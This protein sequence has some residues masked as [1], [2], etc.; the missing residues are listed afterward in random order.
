MTGDHIGRSLRRLEDERFLTGQG[1]YVDDIAVPGQLHGVVLRSPHGHAVIEGIDAAAARVMPGVHGVLTA[2]DLDADGIGTLPCIARVATVAPMVVPP[3]RALARDRVRHVGDP[4]VFVVADTAEQARDAAER[5]DVA[6]RPLP[7]VV[8]AKDA[9]AAQAPLLWDEAPGNLSYRFERGDKPAV[10]AAFAAAAHIIEIELVNNRLVVAPIEPRAAIGTYDAAADS[11][12]LLLTGQGVHSLRQQLAAAVFNMPPERITVR[13]PD[14][15]GGFGVKNF[16]Y[17]EWV[18]V[19]WAARRLGRP[20]KWVADRGEEFV[21]SA[22]GRDNHTRARLAL[23]RDGRYLALDVDT[24]ANLGAYLSTNGPGSSTNS[25]ASAMGGVYDIPAVFMAVRGVFTNTVP[26]DAYRGAGKPEANYLIERLV[27]RAA[28]RLALDPVALRRRNL[29]SSFPHRSA[30]GVTIDCG[31]FA[32]NLD[33]MAQRLL[34]DGFNARQQA[35]AQRGRLRGLGIACFL[36]TSRGTPGERA[37]IRFEPDGRVALVLGTQ[38][39]GQG[40]ETSFPQIAADLLGLPIEAFRFVQADTSAVK[41]GNGHGGARSMHMGGSALYLAAQMVLSKARAIAAHLLQA[42]AS[43]VSFSAGRF[44]VGGSERGIDLLALAEAARDPGNLSDGMTPGLDADAYNDSDVFTFPN[45]CHT[46]EVEID[47]ETGTVTLERYLAI[48]D[49]GRLINP[50][51]TRGQ[52]QG[53]VAQG[54]GQALLEHTVYDEQSGQLPS[55]S[56][57]D[58]A[59]P[60]A[61]DLPPL[62]ITLAELPTSVNQLGVKGAGQAGCMAAPQTVVNAILDALA[63]LGIAHIDMPATPER[64][65]RAIRSAP[66]G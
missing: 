66:G 37:E 23:D 5:V 57:L 47:P 7:A 63:P 49:Y 20:V 42:D 59:L 25:P 54:I 13:A 61:D 4:V 2:A 48:D 58:Y 34:A 36:E 6:Y 15:G 64:V 1:R 45:G 29:I 16:L 51:L 56:F 28:R 27:D 9:L 38:S 62:D 33:E 35:A 14:V 21:S 8:D 19:L 17:P 46:A 12:D 60:R 39:N 40:H 53:G 52:V 32:A 43:E 22:Q 11:F 55:G 18:L 10:D 50:M 31:R 65:W 44:T 26:I 3:R 41:S 30:L 24:V